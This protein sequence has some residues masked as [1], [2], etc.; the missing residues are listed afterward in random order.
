M[1]RYNLFWL[2]LVYNGCF[3]SPLLGL[4]VVVIKRVIVF[5][6]RITMLIKIAISKESHNA[7]FAKD[8]AMLKISEIS[9]EVTKQN[10]LEKMKMVIVIYIMLVN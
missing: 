9:K 7:S 5:V 6:K 8:L 1:D 4:F 3:W 2:F 10:V